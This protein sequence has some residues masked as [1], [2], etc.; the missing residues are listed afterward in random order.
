MKLSIGVLAFL[1]F[2]FLGKAQQT[3]FQPGITFTD[4][5]VTALVTGPTLPCPVFFDWCKTLNTSQL[6]WFYVSTTD[7]TITT[8]QAT[9][10]YTPNDG[11][12][13]VTL[14]GKCDVPTIVVPGK[15]PGLAL[16]VLTLPYPATVKSATI[17]PVGP[18]QTS[19]VVF[20]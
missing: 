11:S 1:C 5:S 15:V 10:V 7:P 19:L 17:S 2:S 4:G 3:T 9:A 8:F 14:I 20:P 12:A 16:I 18:K 6:L 13:D